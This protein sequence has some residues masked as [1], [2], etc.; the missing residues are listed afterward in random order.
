MLPLG[1]RGTSE[2]IVTLQYRDILLH[3]EAVINIRAAIL[4]E[5]L[6]L[7]LL[8]L[9]ILMRY[10]GYDPSAIRRHYNIRV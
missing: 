9:C 1:I 4:I 10:R 7:L 6:M 3:R 2:T 8:E 5:C